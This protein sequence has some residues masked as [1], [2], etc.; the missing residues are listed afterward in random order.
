MKN[1]NPKKLYS[2]K[3]TLTVL[4][5]LITVFSVYAQNKNFQ[6]AKWLLPQPQ[7]I[8]VGAQMQQLKEGRILIELDTNYSPQ[9]FRAVKDLQTEICPWAGTREIT[10]SLAKDEI[11]SIRLQLNETFNKEQGYHLSINSGLIS[12]VASDE[13]GLYY[14]IS[15]LKQLTAYARVTGHLPEVEI[16]DF[17]DIEKRGIMLDISRDKVPTMKSLYELVDRMSAWKMNELQL[18]T[19]HTFAY[20]NH[21]KVWQHASPMTAE[22]ILEL[23]QYCKDHFIDLVPNQNSFGHMKRW[24]QHDEYKHLA[25]CENPSDSKSGRRSRESLNP[26]EEGSLELME[27]LYNEL[28]PNFSSEYV[29]IGCDEV[30]TLGQGRSKEIVDKKGKGQVYLDYITNLNELVKRHDKKAMFW[31]DMI[32]HN[33]ELIK[34]LP[35]DMVTMIWGYCANHPFNKQ[36]PLFEQAKLP[37]YVCPGTSTWQTIVGSYDNGIG[38]LINAAE[39]GKK[40]QAKGYLVTDWGDHGHWQPSMVS[41]PGYLYGAAVSWAVEANRNI[42][43]PK[44]LNFHVFKDKGKAM[45]ELLAQL[46]KTNAY[47]GWQ[48]R[49]FSVY[50]ALAPNS[51]YA[52][53]PEYTKEELEGII[54]HLEKS[55]ELFN[56][57]DMR[58]EDAE[59]LKQELLTAVAMAKFGCKLGIAQKNHGAKIREYKQIPLSER[60]VLANEL[61]QISYDFK[62]LWLHRNRI[63]GLRE[64][65]GRME[66][67]VR[68][69]REE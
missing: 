37:F 48:R 29:N 6:P 30:F 38:N 52:F 36:C 22:E 23:D 49:Y 14:A 7:K 54:I 32:L 46:G 41:Y 59:L 50:R 61:E 43:V 68:K 20:T 28:L 35:K 57:V 44:S 25:I 66:G 39:N 2:K 4:V 15:T 3:S 8:E 62:E 51:N 67:I 9:I 18:Y 10:R 11:P 31:S 53:N 13:A 55:M 45:G 5:V 26:S 42:D 47:K 34:D 40:Y 21:K 33:H 1:L 58:C 64:S 12:V 19:E 27:E 60:L 65:A 17:P 56:E 24:L 69:L 63:G 16:H